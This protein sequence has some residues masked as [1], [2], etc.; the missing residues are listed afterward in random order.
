MA[1][2]GLADGVRAYQQGVQWSQQQEQI[3]KQ[4]QMQADIEEANKAGMAVIA[5]SQQEWQA[6]GAPGQYRPNSETMFRAAEARG[7]ALAKKGHFDAFMENEARIAPMRLRAR[8]EALQRY[9]AD[10]D[11]D[12]LAR[13]VYP[14]LFDGMT[15]KGSRVVGG[16]DDSQ[17]P[18]EAPKYEFELSNGQKATLDPTKFIGT[19]KASMVDPT[20]T[21]KREALLNFER[22]KQNIHTAGRLKE[23]DAQGKNAKEVAQIGADSREN[24]AGINADARVE[25]AD[26]RGR[27]SEKTAT[28]RGQFQKLAADA[29]GGGAGGGRT[30]ETLQRFKALEM[31]SRSSMESI[32][33][34]MIAKEALLKDAG[35]RDRPRI[36]AAV[37]ELKTQLTDA[38]NAHAEIAASLLQAPAPGGGLSEATP[39]AAPEAAPASAPGLSAAS[40]SEL[41]LRAQVALTPEE[42]ARSDQ[43]ERNPQYRVE[44]KAEIDKLRKD[45]A[46]GWQDRV[47]ILEAE[48]RRLDEGGG[49]ADV[50]P[51]PKKAGAA[52]KP[53]AAASTPAA[54]NDEKFTKG[55]VYKDAK[56]N[57]A[58]YLG[59]GKWGPA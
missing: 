28:I 40:P 1:G 38:R 2:L 48:Q 42:Q 16:N 52:P 8:G 25:A 45:K 18:P 24:V 36:E 56:G 57:R 15:I 50:K 39:G 22:E 13:S 11:F 53:A 58:R 20:E 31:A 55:K 33:K 46:E 6:M 32:R 43:I 47:A 51:A 4:R 59:G 21:A 12:R 5:Q 29:R 34:E 44:L 23:I 17:G 19:L 7:S 14:T 27:W 9:E 54:A 26:I 30:S 49:L 35:S 37:A 3:A 41:A 10:G